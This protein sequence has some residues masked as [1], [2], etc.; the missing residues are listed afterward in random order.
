MEFIERQCAKRAESAGDIRGFAVLMCVV[1]AV[2]VLVL[3]V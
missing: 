3:G 1:I 2:V